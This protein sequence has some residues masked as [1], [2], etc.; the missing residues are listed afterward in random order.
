MAPIKKAGLRALIAQQRVRADGIRRTIS[1]WKDKPQA[2]ITKAIARTGIDNLKTYWTEYC[3]AHI[4]I[5]SRED[6]AADPYMTE[7]LFNAVEMEVEICEA[8]MVSHLAE[9]AESSSATADGQVRGLSLWSQRSIKLPEFNL[10]KFSGRAEDWAAFSDIFRSTIHTEPHL[11]KTAKLQYLKVCLIGE[12]AEFVKGIEITEANYES[13]WEA[14]KA[15]YHSLYRTVCAHMDSLDQLPRSTKPTVTSLRALSDKAKHTF[16]ALKNLGQ[17][18]EG[19]DF[20]LVHRVVHCLDADTRVLWGAYLKQQ[21][22]IRAKEPRDEDDPT[23]DAGLP[24][25]RLPTF[26]DL[27]M[28]LEDRVESLE[29]GLSGQEPRQREPRLVST[30]RQTFHFQQ[31]KVPLITVIK[32]ELCSADHYIGKCPKFQ[33][34]SVSDRRYDIRR[35][36][37]CFNCLGHHMARVC[38]SSRRCI[39]CNE[40]HHSSLHEGK[41]LPSRTPPPK[42]QA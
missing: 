3:M 34:K 19:W 20:W 28:F 38:N 17:D 4:K 35:L 23:Q 15:R 31:D 32:C 11:S 37:L 29:V 1:R 22:R 24:G 18:I 14:L 33:A 12:A 9:G 13:T 10:P 30:P 6:A 7:N 41:D 42:P 27:T 40:K 2:D 36:G 26:N 5:A 8:D 25:E 39:S 21:E 16:T